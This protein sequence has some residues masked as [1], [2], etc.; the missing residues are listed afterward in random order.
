MQ[1]PMP[2]AQS[3]RLRSH[4]IKMENIKT[5]TNLPL[6]DANRIT[7]Y[8]DKCRKY[9]H[10]VTNPRIED[11]YEQNSLNSF[12]TQPFAKMAKIAKLLI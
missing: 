12:K 4:K 7:E 6:E 9:V 5:W 11:A 8:R 2:G 10:G 3:D 1:G